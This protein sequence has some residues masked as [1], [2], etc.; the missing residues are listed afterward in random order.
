MHVMGKSRV[1]EIRWLAGFY[2]NLLK[3][4]FS[5]TLIDPHGDLA[6]LVLAQLVADGYFDQEDAYRAAPVSGCP[7]RGQSQPLSQLQLPQA[8]V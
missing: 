1:G 4:G 3:A 5:A 8:A 6:R 2:V 7:G